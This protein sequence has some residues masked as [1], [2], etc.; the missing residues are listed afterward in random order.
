MF[1][2][3]SWLKQNKHTN[4]CTYTHNHALA[5]IYTHTH[6]HTLAQGAHAH[7]RTHYKH[8]LSVFFSSAYL[9]NSHQLRKPA[10][11]WVFNTLKTLTQLRTFVHAYTQ[12]CPPRADATYTRLATHTHTSTTGYDR[13]T[14]KQLLT[15]LPRTHDRP[16]KDIY[17]W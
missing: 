17:R 2:F 9:V 12:L 16:Y 10:R 15:T 5:H 6:T 8:E 13:A 3:I 1:I 4:G 11:H 7:T 14:T